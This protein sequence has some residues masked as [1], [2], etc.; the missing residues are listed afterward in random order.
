ML[1]NVAHS[2]KYS[3][4]VF[5]KKIINKNID[6]IYP[7][8]NKGGDK[9]VNFLTIGVN[10]YT[11]QKLNN[12]ELV[13]GEIYLLLLNNEENGVGKKLH[14]ELSAFSTLN[15]FF[16]ISLINIITTKPLNKIIPFN[17]LFII[18]E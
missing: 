14:T 18:M 9:S 13:D 16:K 8:T 3:T 15:K 10:K 5:I 17:T 7:F 2:S 6:K 1:D 12:V 4:H 11:I